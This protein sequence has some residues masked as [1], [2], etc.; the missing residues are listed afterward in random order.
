MIEKKTY[1]G[2]WV[3]NLTPLLNSVPIVIMRS[4]AREYFINSITW[5]YRI[6]NANNLHRENPHTQEI[7]DAYFSIGPDLPAPQRPFGLDFLPSNAPD[8]SLTDRRL[9]F[10]EPGQYFFDN[11]SYREDA[12]IWFWISEQL[13]PL[14]QWCRYFTRV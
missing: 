14:L 9:Y 7:I 1:T 2:T 5:N 4:L 8:P 3:I 10:F 12:F 6:Y 13:L 11:L